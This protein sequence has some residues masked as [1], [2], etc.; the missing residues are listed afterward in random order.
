MKKSKIIILSIILLIYTFCISLTGL[1]GQTIQNV[2]INFIKISLP[3]FLMLLG[4]FFAIFIPIRIWQASERNKQINDEII[5]DQL[6]VQH[7]QNEKELQNKILKML[8]DKDT[9]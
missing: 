9:L 7:S 3:Y 5:K 4:Y 8:S 6:L 1:F 2:L